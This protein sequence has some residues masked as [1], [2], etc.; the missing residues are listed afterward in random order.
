MLAPQEL[1]ELSAPSATGP[2]A[3]AAAQTPRLPLGAL[4]RAPREEGAGSALPVSSRLPAGSRTGAL[5][6]P[7]VDLD[8]LAAVAYQISPP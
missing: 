4:R 6:T 5:F 2:A 7:G 8:H 3:E 1:H